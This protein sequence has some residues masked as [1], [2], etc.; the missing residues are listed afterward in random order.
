MNF[1]LIILI[2]IN[3]KLIILIKII[4]KLINFKLIQNKLL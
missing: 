1:K 3:L 4:L 2:Q